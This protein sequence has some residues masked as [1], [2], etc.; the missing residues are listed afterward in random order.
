MKKLF[1]LLAIFYFTGLTFGQFDVLR[2]EVFY[3]VT[4][5]KNYL[6]KFEVHE[7][8][9]LDEKTA[10]FRIITKK[11]PQVFYIYA[12]Y[13]AEEKKYSSKYLVKTIGYNKE[14][15][16]D[17]FKFNGKIIGVRSTDDDNK[18]RIFFDAFVEGK[19]IKN[20]KPIYEKEIVNENCGS[21]KVAEI[22]NNL[23]LTYIN[24]VEKKNFK[25]NAL[26]LNASNF[27]FLGTVSESITLSEERKGGKINKMKCGN[28]F[29]LSLKCFNDIDNGHF[30]SYFKIDLNQTITQN[31]IFEDEAKF[32][33]LSKMY[34]NNEKPYL[35]IN[36]ID[37][38]K[39]VQYIY[40]MNK[41][42][43][44]YSSENSM[45]GYVLD[46]F[47]H[48][49]S[50]S[51]KMGLDFFEFAESEKI[52]DSL[53]NIYIIGYNKIRHI[54]NNERGDNGFDY[55]NIGVMKINTQNQFAG[56][57]LINRSLIYDEKY[58]VYPTFSFND[59]KMVF[60]DWELAK[61]FENKIYVGCPV[62]KKYGP[63][64]KFYKIKGEIDFERGEV[65]REILEKT[66]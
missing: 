60:I 61:L 24:S 47:R 27:E 44:K 28:A 12:E 65:S 52:M 1:I 33:Q 3:D 20:A 37:N 7:K 58:E 45:D 51:K 62:G 14:F 2:Q 41:G 57:L 29:Y 56:S 43:L 11:I 30:M 25:M 22:S 26:F 59:Q 42:Q 49:K 19:I 8:Y 39:V 50:N 53:G 4:K 6:N 31:V 18:H 55:H 66:K 36:T 21:V 63:I 16:E 38:G 40:E 5:G 35:F 13:N 46:F 10:V 23:I 34:M 9:I 17:I 64:G 32:I 54:Y 15:Y 48:K